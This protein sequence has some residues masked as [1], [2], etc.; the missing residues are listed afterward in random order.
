MVIGS[1]ALLFW[2]ICQHINQDIYQNKRANYGEP[3]FVTSI[4]KNK[5]YGYSLE[6]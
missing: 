5:K 3:I 6:T 2:N 1:T 4:Q